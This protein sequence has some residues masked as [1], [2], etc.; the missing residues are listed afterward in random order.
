MWVWRPS[1]PSMIVSINIIFLFFLSDKTYFF[2]TINFDPGTYYLIV[3]ILSYIFCKTFT[4]SFIFTTSHQPPNAPRRPPPPIKSRAQ[5]S[6]IFEI[7][8]WM[9]TEDWRIEG[10]ENIYPW[11]FY[12]FYFRQKTLFFEIYG[13]NSKKAHS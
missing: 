13:L 4:Y 7:H 1:P 5:I 11:S 8:I 6:I 2:F 10:F 3:N 9:D 12:T